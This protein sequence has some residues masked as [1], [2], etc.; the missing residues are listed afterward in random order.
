MMGIVNV[1]VAI[2]AF[3][4]WRAAPGPKIADVRAGLVAA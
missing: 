2:A 4:V 1:I 3:L